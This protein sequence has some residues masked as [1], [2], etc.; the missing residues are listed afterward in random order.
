[1]QLLGGRY[2]LWICFVWRRYESASSCAEEETKIIKESL[3]ALTLVSLT[4]RNNCVPNDLKYKYIVEILNDNFSI[5]REKY[6]NAQSRDFF[7]H[8]FPYAKENAKL[9]DERHS[10]RK[11]PYYSLVEHE[12]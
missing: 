7:D 12:K 3:V 6:I 11:S 2:T 9:I 4:L 5:G 8:F 1:M 10:S